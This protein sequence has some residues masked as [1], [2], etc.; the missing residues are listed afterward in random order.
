MS[1]CRRQQMPRALFNSCRGEIGGDL[2]RIAHP[3]VAS[4]G[5]LGPWE[6]HYSHFIPCERR[7]LSRLRGIL[8]RQSSQAALPPLYFP[9]PPQRQSC[10]A[11]APTATHRNPALALRPCNST[12]D[13]VRSPRCCEI[14]CLTNVHQHWCRCGSSKLVG[15]RAPNHSRMSRLITQPSQYL[16]PMP[17]PPNLAGHRTSPVRGAGTRQDLWA[18]MDVPCG[19]L[20][21]SA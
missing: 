4:R 21:T 15:G 11:A 17:G 1:H 13:G 2:F 5:A 16:P 7:C 14:L 9:A 8:R 18:Q 3:G 19:A 10:N 12:A 6:Q 20:R